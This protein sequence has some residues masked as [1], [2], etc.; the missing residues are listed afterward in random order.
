VERFLAEIESGDCCFVCGAK[1]G[2]KRFTEEHVI[3]DWVLRDRALHSGK[4]VL[5]NQ[6][7]LMYGR[8]V[9]PCCQECNEQMAAVF[10][11]PL[12]AAFAKRYEGVAELMRTG[13]GTL[14]WLWLALIFVKL[15]LKHRD[16][17][18]HLDRRLGNV[19]MSEA[20]DWTQLHHIHCVVR[21]FYTGAAIDPKVYG[22]LL[23]WPASDA[24]G[25]KSSILPICCRE[26][27]F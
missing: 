6:A 3:P 12:S 24:E 25:A 26:R 21:S 19:K 27:R 20:Y 7:A 2:S 16:L 5:P 10:E 22:S 15:H 18:W 9:V 13:Q 11:V 17:R 14:I 4:I 8:Y 23:V 1:P